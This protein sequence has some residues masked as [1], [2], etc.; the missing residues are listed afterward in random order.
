MTSVHGPIGKLDG[1][2]VPAPHPS[3]DTAHVWV[4]NAQIEVDAKTA[5]TADFRGSFRTKEQQRIDVLDVMC[6]YCRR[7]FEDVADKPCEAKIDNQHLI[8]G[9]QRERKKRKKPVIP[10]NAKVIIAPAPRINRMGVDA[11]I[12]REL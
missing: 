6:K 3:Q 10:A 2:L 9:D 4:V 11:V 12:R 1:P 8:G 5:K 7:A